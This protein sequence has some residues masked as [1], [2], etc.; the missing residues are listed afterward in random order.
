VTSI[1]TASSSGKWLG[2]GDS[3]PQRAEQRLL[4]EILRRSPTSL[5]LDEFQT[6][7]DG[8]IDNH[9]RNQNVGV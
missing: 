6:W 8:L 5:L 9:K 4:L 2:T 3:R 1:R 7:F